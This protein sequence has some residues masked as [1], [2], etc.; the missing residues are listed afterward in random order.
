MAPQ[1]EIAF[2]LSIGGVL[3]VAANL[4][5][6]YLLAQVTPTAA[7]SSPPQL[8]PNPAS[9]FVPALGIYLSLLMV[10]A[11]VG[12]FRHHRRVF[13]LWLVGSFPLIA[14]YSWLVAQNPQLWLEVLW[15]VVLPFIFGATLYRL[16]LLS[17]RTVDPDA[18]NS[19]A[20]GSP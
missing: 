13:T 19:A 6:W 4:M 7:P 9:G 17:N 3:G 16:K 5:W 2:I 1:R 14:G 8:Q 15:L 18:Q 20:R 12:V 10:I 11:G